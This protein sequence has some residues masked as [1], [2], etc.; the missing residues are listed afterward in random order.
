MYEIEK[1]IEIPEGVTGRPKKY[2][3]KDLEIGDSFLVPLAEHES[4][5]IKKVKASLHAISA[6]HKP[7]KFAIRVV[8]GGVRCWRIA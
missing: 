3:L 7:K 4:P 8:E 1:G 2:P 5:K 6:T